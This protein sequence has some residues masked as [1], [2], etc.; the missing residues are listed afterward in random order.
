MVEIIG[1]PGHEVTGFILLEKEVIQGEEFA[2]YLLPQ[3]VLDLPGGTDNQFAHDEE[4]DGQE[5]GK[6]NNV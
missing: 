6:D 1:T 2:V 3:L 5:D 4:G